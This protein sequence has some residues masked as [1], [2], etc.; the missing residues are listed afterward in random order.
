MSKCECFVYNVVYNGLLPK[1]TKVSCKT[2]LYSNM[3][4]NCYKRVEI[5]FDIHLRLY[6]QFLLQIYPEL[7]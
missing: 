7:Q 1:L 4:K 3:I 6:L 5:N 2:Y